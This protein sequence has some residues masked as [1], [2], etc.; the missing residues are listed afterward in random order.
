MAAKINTCRCFYIFLS[1]RSYDHAELLDRGVH[2]KSSI[3][4]FTLLCKLLRHSYVLTVFDPFSP[5]RVG[6]G[7]WVIVGICPISMS[8][9]HSL[10]PSPSPSRKGLKGVKGVD[11]LKQRKTT[12]N[13]KVARY[14]F[15]CSTSSMSILSILS[16][17]T[18]D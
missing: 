7:G 11:T 4:H 17:L 16:V 5:F 6:D 9:I 1:W 8:I 18:D 3:Y 2:E 10:A 12:I 13:L 15:I 14:L